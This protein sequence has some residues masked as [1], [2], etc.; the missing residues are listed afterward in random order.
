M[1]VSVSVSVSENTDTDTDTN[2][3]P[4]KERDDFSPFC[5]GGSR[6]INNL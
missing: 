5:K 1:S 4:R 6:G 2:N 3:L